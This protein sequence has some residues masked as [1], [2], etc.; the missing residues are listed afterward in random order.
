MEHLKQDFTCAHIFRD[1]LAEMRYS[2]FILIPRICSTA[3]NMRS[4]YKALY[5]EM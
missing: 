1:I 2:N 5:P 3:L 4:A